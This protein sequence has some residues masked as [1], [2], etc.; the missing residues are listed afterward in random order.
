MYRTGRHAQRSLL[1]FPILLIGAALLAP[2][3][4]ACDITVKVTNP[5]TAS[6]K[7]DIA[8]LGVKVKGGTWRNIQQHGERILAPG[9]TYT[10]VFS[11]TIGTK[12]CDARR[13]YRVKVTCKSEGSMTGISGTASK[14]W[15]YKPNETGW[16]RKQVV[17]IDTDCR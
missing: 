10:E 9:Q 4:K 14:N 11:P 13:R 16:T 6:T 17:E 5:S 3:S 7:A 1:V 8:K 12:K 15:L 2:P